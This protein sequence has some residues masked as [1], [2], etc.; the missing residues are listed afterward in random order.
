MKVLQDAIHAR[1]VASAIITAGVGTYA[2]VPAVFTRVPVPGKAPDRRITIS[3]S[4]SDGSWDTKTSTGRDVLTDV[5]IWTEESGDPS[6]VESLAEEVRDLFHRKPV[7]VV[8]YGNWLCE[9]GGPIQNDDDQ[10]Y[11]RVI[12]MRHVLV[13]A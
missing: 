11:G 4:I 8:G 5:N 3:S 1:L 9:C 6:L 7:D 10:L 12:S 13:K 2:G